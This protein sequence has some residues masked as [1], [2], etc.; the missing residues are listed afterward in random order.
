MIEI[1]VELVFKTWWWNMLLQIMLQNDFT[2][3]GVW[4]NRA[5]TPLTSEAGNGFSSNL[6]FMRFA[7]KDLK[8]W[9]SQPIFWIHFL[10]LSGL[11]LCFGCSP[12]GQDSINHMS[13][14]PREGYLCP[15]HIEY[16]AHHKILNWV[17]SKHILHDKLSHKF[18]LFFPSISNSYSIWV[19]RKINILQ[20]EKI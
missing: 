17:S 15:P 1:H 13:A 5:V 3:A 14:G 16:M 12:K 18:H 2:Q 20:T 10:N 9:H 4:S 6:H 7:Q 11:K 8:R 19:H